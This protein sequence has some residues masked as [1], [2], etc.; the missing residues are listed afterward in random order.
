M[1]SLEV[2][3]FITAINNRPM[4]TFFFSLKEWMSEQMEGPTHFLKSHEKRSMWNAKAGQCSP[5][6]ERQVKRFPHVSSGSSKCLLAH[7]LKRNFVCPFKHHFFLNLRGPFQYYGHDIIV[8]ASITDFRTAEWD[9][10]RQFTIMLWAHG[11]KTHTHTHT[12]VHTLPL[13]HHICKR[14]VF[15][16]YK[17]QRS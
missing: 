15:T 6:I 8:P 4:D 5:G 9:P 7:H 17:G 11:H 12:H 16:E 10:Q 1:Y 3:S 13:Y 14:K 2:L